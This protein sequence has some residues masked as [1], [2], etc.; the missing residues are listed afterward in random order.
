[1]SIKISNLTNN[2]VRNFVQQVE[3]KI[4]NIKNLYERKPTLFLTE[5]DIKCNLYAEIIKLQSL[6]PNNTPLVYTELAENIGNNRNNLMRSDM[7]VFMPNHLNLSLGSE[8]QYIDK[9][10]KATGKYIDIEIKFNRNGLLNENEIQADI[11]KLIALQN[12]NDNDNELLFSFMIVGSR[13]FIDVD[14]RNR[15]NELVEH[16]SKIDII[17][18]CPN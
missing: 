6:N 1:M 14:I 16:Q 10:F 3:G 15:L 13:S 11:D 8:T 17:Y 2:Q 18:M 7:T 4:F 9:H 12:I 5:S